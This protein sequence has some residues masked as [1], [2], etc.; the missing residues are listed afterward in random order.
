[1]NNHNLA[2]GTTLP[3]SDIV[4]AVVVIVAALNSVRVNINLDNSVMVDGISTVRG[5]LLACEDRALA[6]SNRENVFQFDGKS[7]TLQYGGKLVTNET[8][9]ECTTSTPNSKSRYE[10]WLGN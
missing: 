5:P 8:D 9:W 3:N 2:D 6:A 4:Q 1:M 7:C 10:P